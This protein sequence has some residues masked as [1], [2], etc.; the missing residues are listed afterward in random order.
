MR[1]IEIVKKGMF[2]TERVRLNIPV[3]WSELSPE[4]FLLIAESFCKDISDKDF[5]SKLIGYKVNNLPD[6]FIYLNSATLL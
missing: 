5:I 4:Q 2:R 3:K 1:T 6:Y